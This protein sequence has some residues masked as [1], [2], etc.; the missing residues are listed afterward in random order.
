MDLNSYEIGLL[1]E[2]LIVITIVIK[3]YFREKIKPTT[4]GS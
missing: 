4:C 1:I 2:K 3:T